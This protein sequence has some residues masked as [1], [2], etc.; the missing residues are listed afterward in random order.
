MK[1]SKRLNPLTS[2]DLVVSPLLRRKT[3]IRKWKQMIFTNLVRFGPRGRA[4]IWISPADKCSGCTLYYV[5]QPVY[6]VNSRHHIIIQSAANINTGTEK[7]CRTTLYV[8]TTIYAYLRI[9]L[10]AERSGSLGISV[11]C[12][13]RWWEWVIHSPRSDLSHLVRETLR[14]ASREHPANI[15]GWG[16]GSS[17]CL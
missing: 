1:V 16:I 5:A 12:C 15:W 2:N 4:G 6:F 8:K 9:F 13:G 11:Q 3:W 14:P 10:R 7:V 17:E